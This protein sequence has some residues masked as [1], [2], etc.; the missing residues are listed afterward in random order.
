MRKN[1]SLSHHLVTSQCYFY[2]MPER[3]FGV[4]LQKTIIRSNP[5]Y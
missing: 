4:Q 1:I 2:K 5:L 3:V